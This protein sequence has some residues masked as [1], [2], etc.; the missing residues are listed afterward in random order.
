MNDFADPQRNACRMLML[1]NFA[2]MHVLACEAGSAPLACEA[3]YA[4]QDGSQMAVAKKN[5][6]FHAKG[7]K[8]LR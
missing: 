8:N 5:M 1:L 6:H 4:L 2:M 7:K 3:I